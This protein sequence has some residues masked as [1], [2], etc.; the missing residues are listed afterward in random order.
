MVS[1]DWPVSVSIPVPA[2]PRS[3]TLPW[4]LAAQDRPPVVARS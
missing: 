2:T 1:P 4:A 3:V